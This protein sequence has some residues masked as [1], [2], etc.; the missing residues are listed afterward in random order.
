MIWALLYQL[1]EFENQLNLRVRWDAAE[2]SVESEGDS[3]CM[4]DSSL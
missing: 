3:R 1:L 2:N 4:T